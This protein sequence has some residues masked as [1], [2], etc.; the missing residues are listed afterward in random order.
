MTTKLDK[1]NEMLVEGDQARHVIAAALEDADVPCDRG[2]VVGLIMTA[3]INA[4]AGS[5]PISHESF[6]FLCSL[7]YKA[8]EIRPCAGAA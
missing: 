2:A 5:P 8:M 7:V 4:K 1:L 3:A 6:T